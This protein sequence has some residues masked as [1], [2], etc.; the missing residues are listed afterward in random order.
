MC[1]MKKRSVNYFNK[2]T[3]EL[4]QISNQLKSLVEEIVLSRKQIKIT[5]SISN[6][7]AKKLFD[8]GNLALAGTVFVHF[9]P[10][11]ELS[12]SKVLP[13]M[14]IFASLYLLAYLISK[15]R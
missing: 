4:T 1:V 12:I 8:L 7:L 6:I 2:I 13:G 11:K 3:Q 15:E 5:S 9:I 10:G 14:A